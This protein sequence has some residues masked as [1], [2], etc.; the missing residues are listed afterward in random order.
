[1]SAASL[2]NTK[3]AGYAVLLIGGA[4][5][6]YYVGKKAASAVSD[7]LPA[8]GEAVDPVNPNNVANKAFNHFYEGFTGRPGATFGGDLFDVLHPFDALPDAPLPDLG[9]SAD[10]TYTDPLGNTH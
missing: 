7:A 9:V 4:L 8:I 3:A 5:I 6:L 2:L 10:D 1:M